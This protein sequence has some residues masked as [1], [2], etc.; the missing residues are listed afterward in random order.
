MSSDRER[1]FRQR[2]RG[3]RRKR[4]H[5]SNSTKTSDWTGLE[6]LEQRM[7]LSTI[8]W[9]G[10]VS[11]DWNVAANWVDDVKPGPDDDAVIGAAFAADTITSDASEAINTVTS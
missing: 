7:L 9:D 11:N 8:N 5:L 4:R 3:I 1:L 6:V 2:R 10:D